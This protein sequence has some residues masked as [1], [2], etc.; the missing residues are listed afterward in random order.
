MVGGKN[1]VQDLLLSGESAWQTYPTIGDS[2]LRCVLWT[3]KQQLTLNIFV[4]R[5][6]GYVYSMW[7][8]KIW[9]KFRKMK[10]LPFLTIDF[11]ICLYI[12]DVLINHMKYFDYTLPLLQNF[13]KT[14][15][16]KNFDWNS[17][18]FS[19]LKW[20]L[21]KDLENWQSVVKYFTWCIKI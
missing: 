6:S 1:N 20:L 2:I 21:L 15:C 14:I 7:I 9:F 19:A 16:V 8:D 13:T 11:K 12:L 4:L 5:L 18:K 10:Y 3:F 17:F